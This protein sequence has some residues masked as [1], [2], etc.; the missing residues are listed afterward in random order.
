M[1][2]PNKEHTDTI[3]EIAAYQYPTDSA[4]ETGPEGHDFP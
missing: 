2:E 4:T 3:Q 1:I